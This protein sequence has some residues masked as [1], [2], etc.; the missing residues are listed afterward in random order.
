[1]FEFL[2]GRKKRCVRRK[3]ACK[4]VCR[5]RRR[6]CA[7]CS[8]MTSFGR[9]CRP[10][11]CRTSDC[12]VKMPCPPTMDD[13]LNQDRNDLT[14]WPK[15]VKKYYDND[16]DQP[17][18][19][20]ALGKYCGDK[21]R[22]RIRKYIGDECRYTCGPNKYRDPW[23]EEGVSCGKPCVSLKTYLSRFD[24]KTG[25]LNDSPMNKKL[26]ML[27]DKA[28]AAAAAADVSFGF[29]RD[30]RPRRPKRRNCDM[31]CPTTATFI[32]GGDDKL[33]REDLTKWK[34]SS[35][36]DV[37]LGKYC[38]D[39]PRC[40]IPKY[41][42]SA[43]KYMCGANKYKNIFYDIDDPCSKPCVSWAQY[44][45][46]WQQF[47]KKC[48]KENYTDIQIDQEFKKYFPIKTAAAFGRRRKCSRKKAK[49]C[50]KKLPKAIVT[51]CRKLK[52]K[53]TIKR[54]SRRVPRSLTLLKR[55]IAR[56]MRRCKKK[57]TCR[58]R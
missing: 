33:F 20:A 28:A 30:C 3:P 45:K 57:S 27:N 48:K 34:C 23:F 35:P 7:P 29:S 19:E 36:Y 47:Y 32:G 25:K 31:P 43:C 44:A 21:P 13:I 53:T 46:N 50:H 51:K 16:L 41:I 9:D 1:M 12:Y 4:P 37:K 24:Q 11:R 54:G 58:R 38:G 55:L 17:L 39:K 14:K 26:L 49:K 56:K 18:F 52:I 40:G 5:R 8:P 42:G 10:R 22:Y 6:R 15:Y 2:F